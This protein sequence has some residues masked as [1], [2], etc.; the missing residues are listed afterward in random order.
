MAVDT[1]S[2]RSAALGF[3]SPW[4][5]GTHPPSGT[6]SAFERGAI[7]GAYYV[8]LIVVT[9]VPYEGWYADVESVVWYADVEPVV[10]GAGNENVVW[11]TEL[12][13]P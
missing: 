7:L 11:A 2:K 6:I 8:E 5:S 4:R 10:Y 12:E 13:N 1:A 3:G 9:T